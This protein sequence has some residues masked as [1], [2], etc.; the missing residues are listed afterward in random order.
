LIVEIVGDSRSLERA[1]RRSERSASTFGGRMSAR[2]GRAGVVAGAALGAGLVAGMQQSV[3]QAMEAQK[4]L[5][6]TQVALKNVGA[7]WA[8]YGKRIE[9]TTTSLSRLASVNDEEL[10]QSFTVLLRGT[11][12]VTRALQLNTVAADLA[13]ARNMDLVSAATLLVKV[14]AGNLG[15]LR[16]LGI[17]V[18]KNATSQEALALVQ[19][20]YAGAAEAYGRSAAGAQDRFRIAVEELEESIGAKLLPTVT[21]YLKRATAWLENAKNVKLVTDTLG[22]AFD[23]I[24]LEIEVV[25]GAFNKAAAAARGFHDAVQKLSLD[26]SLRDLAKDLKTIGGAPVEIKWKFPAGWGPGHALDELESLRATRDVGRMAAR[27]DRPRIP[28]VVSGTKQLPRGPSVELRNRWFDSMIARMLDRV[29]DV[30]ALRGQIAQLRTIGGLIQQR[31]AATRDVTRRLALEDQFRGVMREIR[32]KQTQMADDARAAADANKERQEAA[33]DELLGWLD[34]ALR[35]AEMTK[36]LRDD[37]KILRT[38]LKVIR[39]RIRLH[40]L[41]L[42]LATKEQDI[43]ERIADKR[44]QTEKGITEY[45][46]PSVGKL[47]RGLGLTPAEMARFRFNLRGLDITAAGGGGVTIDN[48]MRVDLDGRQ[49]AVATRRHTVKA[50]QRTPSQ[51][52]GRQVK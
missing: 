29:Q 31:I 2:L 36:P 8:V 17:M 11:K 27:P 42:E 6:Q 26:Y 18:D 30:R 38:Q 49:V 47:V 33:R 45:R 13:R 3:K 43:L 1:L 48:R 51:T 16:R 10:L 19:R 5:G 32:A 23:Y 41:T 21:R 9:T 22:V 39:E 20:R 44:K 24:A 50:Q 46:L 52:R 4:V 7:S 12:D 40:G 28:A 14:N 35:R 37:L 15:S 34:L 25:A